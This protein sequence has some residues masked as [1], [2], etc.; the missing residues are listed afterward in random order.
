MADADDADEERRRRAAALLDALQLGDWSGLED[1]IAGEV[2]PVYADGLRAVGFTGDVQTT[3]NE[4]RANLG[5]PPLEE[6]GDEVPEILGEMS[7][8]AASWARRQVADLIDGLKERTPGMLEATVAAAM[9]GD[10]TAQVL[11]RAIADS[12][13]FSSGRAKTI[14]DNETTQAEREGLNTA[15][16]GTNVARGKQ[17]FT[18]EDEAVEEDCDE[19]ADAGVIPLEDD[20]PNGDWPHIGCRCWWELFDLDQDEE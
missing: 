2:A 13:A 11:A 16:R 9:S 12:P 15:M 18:Q 5:L 6:G 7:D 17:W 4:A 10:L 8:R 14:A 1:D 19:N 20:F 3:R